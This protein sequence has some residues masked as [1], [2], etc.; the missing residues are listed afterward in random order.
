MRELNG[1]E[2]LEEL[3]GEELGVSDWHTVGQEQIQ[4]FADATH[5]QQWIHT[6]PEKAAAG[7]FG[8]PVAHGY[9]TLSMLPFFAKQVYQVNG[10]KMTVNYGLNKVR[11]PSPVPVGARMRDRMSL[12]SVTHGAQGAQAVCRH[13]IE[14]EGTERP[15]CVAETISLLVE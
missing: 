3:I 13:E 4:G 11:F 14:I 5:D 9:L 2:E 12:V 15:G 8:R 7:P 1:L 6:D 10:L